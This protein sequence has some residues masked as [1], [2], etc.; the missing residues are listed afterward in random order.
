M[1]IIRR[2]SNGTGFGN[3][4]PGDSTPDLWHLY[5]DQ[6][7]ISYSV[8]PQGEIIGNPGYISTT[9]NGIVYALDRR[10]EYTSWYDT[11]WRHSRSIRADPLVDYY[12]WS[13]ESGNVLLLR[14]KGASYIPR[15]LSSL[16]P[17]FRISDAEVAEGER[18][19]L[20]I[21]RSG[22]FESSIQLAIRSRASTAQPGSLFDYS[23]YLND[24]RESVVFNPGEISKRI[25]VDTY[26]DSKKEGWEAFY[27]DIS[28]GGSNPT[29]VIL[30]KGTAR[31]DIK[32]L[33]P[34]V[35]TGSGSTTKI[36]WITGDSVFAR[37]GPYGSADLV[38]VDYKTGV[39][40]T[41]GK[42]EIDPKTLRIE[43]DWGTDQDDEMVR[44]DSNISVRIGSTWTDF[45]PT[46]KRRPSV[47]TKPKQYSLS[48]SKSL[49]AYVNEQGNL[50]VASTRSGKSVDLGIY[51]SD[52]YV[53]DGSKIL[54]ETHSIPATSPGSSNWGSILL[55]L[56]LS[57]DFHAEA[58]VQ[59]AS[60]SIADAQGYEGDAITTLVTRTGNTDAAQNIKLSWTNG[61]AFQGFDFIPPSAS[62]RFEAGE[63]SKQVTVQTKED[64]LVE[65]D[66]WFGLTIS[67]TDQG[68][69]FSDAD[70]VITILND[71]ESAPIINNIVNNYYDVTNTTNNNNTWNT[72]NIDNSIKIEKLVVQWFERPGA[73]PQVTV[74]QENKVLDIKAS[75]WSDKVLL[76][77]VGQAAESGGLLEA[78]QIDFLP[79]DRQGSVLN[80]G[81]GRD[82]V[83]AK[84]GWDV[85][86][87]GDNNDYIRAGN[88]RDIITGGKGA[89][90]LW[91]DFGWNTYT[92]EKDG[93]RDLIAIK[94]D[95][96]LINWLNGKAGNNPNGEK[97]D[98]IE[99]LDSN[100][101]I[102]I[103]GVSTED[104]SF[105]NA[106]AHGVSGIGIYG[107]GALEAVYTGGDLSIDQIRAMT[108]GD[109]TFAGGGYGWTG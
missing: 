43:N 87:G 98:I 46:T 37:P 14:D 57:E 29:P 49:M 16:L 45:G 71:D 23:N 13:K 99:G 100:D 74:P 93:Y 89:D 51:G 58:P 109:L 32:D 19:W 75:S 62:I 97:A 27:V 5:D 30:A 61:T 31:V 65:R 69:E 108:S 48:E 20:T 28:E 84:A 82:V 104:L 80:G 9:R 68:I 44:Y 102:K 10:G 41:G 26:T 42:I 18:A 7:P 105:G 36:A 85:I 56:G 91:G 78:A 52:P 2:F 22:S 92:S 35:N 47:A 24:Q 96:Y 59:K 101:V 77:S 106:T 21:E 4:S 79:T 103:L 60:F 40:V 53:I 64:T 34:A 33:F 86:D 76:K 107:R 55:E 8:D 90:E 70:A 6:T 15:E 83:M 73:A 25:F 72:F 50:N 39:I 38:S 95:E 11:A 66:E 94:S 63:T 67:S 17:T 54:F 81:A 12:W 1:S 3:T 88:G